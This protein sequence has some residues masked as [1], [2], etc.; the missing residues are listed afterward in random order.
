MFHIISNDRL[1]VSRIERMRLGE[2]VTKIE[3]RLNS[4]HLEEIGSK[5][6]FSFQFQQNSNHHQ[7]DQTLI[8]QSKEQDNRE[9]QEEEERGG[10]F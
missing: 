6:D 1:K 7:Q 10:Y 4:S 2:R 5:P 8:F 9:E 3:G